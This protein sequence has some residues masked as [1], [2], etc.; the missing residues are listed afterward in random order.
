MQSLLEF[1]IKRIEYR[2]GD[3]QERNVDVPHQLMQD[4]CL[5][6]QTRALLEKRD[7]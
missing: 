1:C 6:L 3:C 7:G 4:Y 2:I 5:L